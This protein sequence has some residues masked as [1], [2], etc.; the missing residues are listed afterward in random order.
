M[1]IAIVVFLAALILPNYGKGR[2]QYALLRSAHK[3]AQDLRKAQEMATSAKEFAGQ[4]PIGGYGIHSRENYTYYILFADLNGNG[5]Y[6]SEPTDELVEKIYFE[7]GV[8]ISDL[9]FFGFHVTFIPP[10][11]QVSIL[12]DSPSLWIELTIDGKTKTVRV[13]KAGLISVD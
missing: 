4:V 5:G 2:E 8:K 12:P 1:V 6:D 7:K 3:L 10:D 11:P 9:P 13:N